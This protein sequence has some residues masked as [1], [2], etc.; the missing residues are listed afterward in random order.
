VKIVLL[1]ILIMLALIPGLFAIPAQAQSATDADIEASI[2][3]GIAWLADNQNADGS[4]GTLA[5]VAITGFAVL[6][7]EDRAFELGFD[8]PFDEGY[9]YHENVKKGLDY[10]FAHA[11]IVPI[12]VQPAGNPDDASNNGTG[13]HFFSPLTDNK[14]IYETGIVMMAIAASRS[15]DELAIIPGSTIGPWTYKQVLQDAVDYLAWGQVDGGTGR[16]GWRYEA[17]NPDENNEKADNSCSGY[18]VIGLGYAENPLYRF[19]CKVPQFVRT[20]LADHWIPNIQNLGDGGSY[21]MEPPLMGISMISGTFLGIP[22]TSVGLVCTSTLTST[23][24]SP[25]A[26]KAS[27]ELPW[28]FLGTVRARARSGLRFSD[29]ASPAGRRPP[30]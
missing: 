28:V 4:W 30:L 6:K 18:A 11:R 14:T 15:P 22:V 29:Q 20:E 17:N 26:C 24:S 7:L 1:S 13:V 12:S 3:A 9:Q 21:Y 2:A 10:I 5:E 27:A 8:S 19:C 25:R 16:G 23:I